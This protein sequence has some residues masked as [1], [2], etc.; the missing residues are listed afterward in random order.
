MEKLVQFYVTCFACTVAFSLLEFRFTRGRK[1]DR[2]VGFRNRLPTMYQ[3]AD[4]CLSL[5]IC[6]SFNFDKKN[7]ICHIA[8]R[9]WSPDSLSVDENFVYALRGDIP[10]VS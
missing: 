10:Q 6:K 8:T 7:K 5:D 9:S 3:C 4:L 1:I 2:A